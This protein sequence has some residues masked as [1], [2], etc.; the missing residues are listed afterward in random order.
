M[1]IAYLLTQN[2]DSPS[3]LGRY[4]PL[5]RAMV[6]LGH[7]VEVYALHPDFNSL[8]ARSFNEEGVA[9]HYVAP[10][11]VKKRGSLK[12]YY[13]GWTLAPLVVY[14]AGKLAQ[15]ALSSKA[16]I[17]HL[18]K[19]HPMN[20]AAGILAK[21]INRKRLF[22]DCDD[23]EAGSNR[24]ANR[25]QTQGVAFFEQRTPAYAEAVTT[26]TK[27]MEQKLVEWGIKPGKIHYLP[28][29]VELSRFTSPSQ[30]QIESLKAALGLQERRVVA[31]IGSLSLPSHPVDFLVRAFAQVAQ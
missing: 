7:Q 8:S 3:G 6:R 5:A 20:S 28:N 10:M 14:A 1:R 2:L 30:M 18:G 27:F 23:Y 22:L 9:V 29:G 26:N 21:K 13:P 17:I 19:P 25:W 31:F 16:D 11:H 4:G 15:A 24:F 12:S